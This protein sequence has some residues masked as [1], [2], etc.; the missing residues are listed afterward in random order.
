MSEQSHYPIN[1][2]LAVSAHINAD[3][4]QQLYQQSINDPESFWA[5]QA[6]AFLDWQ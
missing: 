3:R 6:E 2:A 4:Y 1:P 5:E